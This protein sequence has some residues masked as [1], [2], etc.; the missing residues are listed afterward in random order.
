[1]IVLDTNVV[2]E[3]VQPIPSLAVRKWMSQY[4]RHDLY[5]TAI[6]EAEM[7]AGVAALPAGK[8][9][10]TLSLHIVKIFAQDFAGRILPFD[11]EAARQYA[12]V[13]RR[14]HGKPMMEPD[15]QIAAIAKAHGAILATRNIKHFKDCGITIVN[16]WTGEYP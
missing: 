4:G 15:A 7:F 1:M 3:P 12:T 5:T 14:V 16:P 8:R 10:E 2:S 13:A 9:R 11:S 6:T